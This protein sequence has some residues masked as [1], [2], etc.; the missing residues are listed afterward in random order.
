MVFRLDKKA[1]YT[2][3]HLRYHSDFTP[4][5]NKP[6]TPQTAI[7]SVSVEGKSASGRDWLKLLPMPVSS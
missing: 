6:F 5:Q 1:V 4:V 7:F 3:M 2:E